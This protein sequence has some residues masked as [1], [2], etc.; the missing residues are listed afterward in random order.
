METVIQKFLTVGSIHANEFITTSVLMKF[1]EDYCFAYVNNKEIYGYDANLL[2]R[3]T[4]LYIVPM[5]NPDGVDLVNGKI[6]KGSSVYNKAQNMSNN[7]PSISCP[8]R[9]ESKH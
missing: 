5:I 1:L 4:S 9:M 3:T 2:Y 8:S 7:F 6:K